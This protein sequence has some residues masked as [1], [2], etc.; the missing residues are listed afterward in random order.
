MISTLQFFVPKGLIEI[1]AHIN[2]ITVAVL[3][4]TD[5]ARGKSRWFESLPSTL[6]AI[7]IRNLL[8]LAPDLAKNLLGIFPN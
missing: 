3:L 5:K 4:N 1:P 7:W 8:N 6:A 2:F